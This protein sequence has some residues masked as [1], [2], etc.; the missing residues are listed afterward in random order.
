MFGGMN[1]V[2]DIF[3]WTLGWLL[4]N[5]VI[6]P[7]LLIIGY[8]LI[9]LALG[10][11][12]Q[13]V[14]PGQ[15]STAKFFIP[16]MRYKF[17]VDDYNLPVWLFYGLIANI[18]GLLIIALI[19]WD[20]FIYLIP[21]QGV[22]IIS[23]AY[24]WGKIGERLGITFWVMFLIGLAGAFS[25]WLCWLPPLY[26]AFGPNLPID[27]N[28]S[29][30]DGPEEEDELDP[31]EIPGHGEMRL[32]CVYGAC[33][34]KIIYASNHKATIGRSTEC[35]FVVPFPEISRVHAE[36]VFDANSAV[37]IDMSQNGVYLVSGNCKTRVVDNA[38]LI[39]GDMFEI[40]MPPTRFRLL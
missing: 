13:K 26:L 31:D 27:I 28:S 15:T 35:D 12:S 37:V 19:G 38:K 22:V 14:K 34:G 7:I 21:L 6:G 8:I 4:R 24:L 1:P 2:A 25:V 17:I 9:S 36:V 16:I 30:H 3:N 40:G 5:L 32:A 18:I 29:H 39:R 20:G 23:V 33:K 11:M 10:K